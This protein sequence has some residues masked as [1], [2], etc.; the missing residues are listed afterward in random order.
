MAGRTIDI[1]EYIGVPDALASAISNQFD[2]W[3]R[4]RSVWLEEKKELRNYVFAT[5]TTKTTN[6]SLPWKNS[7]TIPKLCQIRDNLHANYMAALFP[8]DDWLLW[9]GDDEDAEAVEKRKVILA[10]MQNKIRNSGFINAVSELVY[11][12]IDF[13]NVLGSTEY[14]NEVR[15]NKDTGEVI[16]GYVGPRAVRVSPFDVVMNPVAAHFENA[17][18]IIRVIKSL[19]EIAAD[20]EDHPEAGYLEDVFKIMTEARKS[21][22][23]LTTNDIHQAEGLNIDGFGSLLEYYQSGYVEILEFHGDMYDVHSEELLKN[24]IIT[25]VDRSHILRK[26]PNPSWRGQSLRHAGWR[27]RPGNL[28]AMGPLDNL[29]GMQY[30]LDHLENLKADVFDFIAHPVL[31]ISGHVE[32]FDYGPGETI[33][34]GDEGDVQF[35]HPDTTALNADMQID[36][37]EAKMEDMVGAPK[38]AMGIRTPGEKTKF[39]VQTLDNASSRIFQ[40]KIT[41]F[42]RN[43]LEPL[44][45]DMLE[46]ARRNME[47]SDVVRVVD[48]EFGAA[49]FETIT[50]EDLASRGKLRPV[51]ARHFAAKANQ[52]QNLNAL[53]NSAIYNDPAVNTH[54]SG[55]TLAQVIEELLDIEKFNLVSPNVRVAEQLET[56]RLIDTG[57]QQLDEERAVAGGPVPDEGIPEG[58]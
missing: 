49:L 14:V 56:Q 44:L 21:V 26:V 58:A 28:W 19:G 46:L 11:D 5:D 8:T 52:F 55:V 54:F 2:D 47:I 6:A 38:Q 22:A 15:E 1:N 42:E 25:I 39:E 35:M 29:V 4:M 40:S 41:Y 53:A 24:H 30:R 36:R 57:A 3:Q 33:Y 16:P 50:P 37:L 12:Y 7:T 51:G 32:D 20:I 31:K 10:Y 34:V 43:F 27:L 45:N 13:G 48:D 23:G 9:E 18:K 17:P